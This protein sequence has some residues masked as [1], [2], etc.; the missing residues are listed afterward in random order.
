MGSAPDG[1]LGSLVEKNYVERYSY[2]YTPL[3]ACHVYSQMIQ[4][5]AVMCSSRAVGILGLQRAAATVGH[6]CLS[7]LDHLVVYTWQTSRVCMH[8]S[9]VDT[10]ST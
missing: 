7:P 2:A 5:P 1:H 4:Q 3:D 6:G 9:I 10:V 8:R